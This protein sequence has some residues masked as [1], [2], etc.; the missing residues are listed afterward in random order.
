[1]SA[2]TSRAYRGIDHLV[3]RT[4]DAASLYELFSGTL[5]LPVTWPLE[6]RAFATFGWIGFGNTNLEIWAAT[7]NSDLPAD[8]PFPLVQQIALE[9]FEL[10]DTLA[11]LKTLGFNCKTPRTFSSKD[12]FGKETANFTNSVLLDLSSDTCCV[13]L[14]D[15]GRE[16]PIVPWTKGLT[17][18][19]RRVLEQDAMRACGGG[20]LGIVGLSEIALSTHDVDDALD[21]WRGLAA[22]KEQA[23][24]I[25]EDVELRLSPGKR[26]VIQSLTF[27]VRDLAHARRFLV[28]NGLLGREEGD[29][30]VLSHHVSQG[31]RFRFVQAAS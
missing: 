21:R 27:S 23:I 12:K 18:Q 11:R 24:K 6:H 9:P 13:F 30:V 26:D 19:E 14:C 31:L 29:A 16:A 22:S 25:A 15:W 28:D 7:D 5:G 1:M 10:S 17:T 8:G 20:A 2:M 3:V 4:A